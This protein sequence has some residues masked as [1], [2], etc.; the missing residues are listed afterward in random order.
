MIGA[1]SMSEDD[2]SGSTVDDVLGSLTEREKQI[3]KQRFGIDVSGNRLLSELG[4]EFD[5]TRERIREI[6]RTALKKLRDPDRGPD[7]AA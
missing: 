5:L 7:D 2:D 4:E 1:N 6:E 3:L